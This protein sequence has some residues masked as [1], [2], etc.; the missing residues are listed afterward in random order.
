MYFNQLSLESFKSIFAILPSLELWIQ[1]DSSNEFPEA[2]IISPNAQ[3]SSGSGWN[4]TSLKSSYS[5]YFSLMVRFN[6]TKL[7]IM[8][9]LIT[10]SSEYSSTCSQ[11]PPWGL[12]HCRSQP[13]LSRSWE[14]WYFSL[15][16][17]LNIFLMLLMNPLMC[18]KRAGH[19]FFGL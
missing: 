13:P 18:N 6:L 1:N 5:K 14:L 11:G 3:R 10:L 15:V 9:I 17:K 8:M 12:W 19:W 7:T 4:K 16:D 2:D